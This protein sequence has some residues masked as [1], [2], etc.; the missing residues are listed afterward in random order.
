VC[1]QYVRSRVHGDVPVLADKRSHQDHWTVPRRGAA[2]KPRARANAA[3]R[4]SAGRALLDRRQR[5]LTTLSIPNIIRSNRREPAHPPIPH[6][7]PMASTRRP[8]GPTSW[9]PPRPTRRG[10]PALELGI[11]AAL[12]WR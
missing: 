7:R 8:R 1:P 4:S 12:G 5:E 6:G 2:R 11:A 9:C 10:A 3:A